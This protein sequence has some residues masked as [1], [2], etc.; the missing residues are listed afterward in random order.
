MSR[1]FSLHYN[2][3]TQSVDILDTPA[4]VSEVVKRVQNDMA[5]VQHALSSFE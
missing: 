4:K 2:P 5:S 3:F 1:P